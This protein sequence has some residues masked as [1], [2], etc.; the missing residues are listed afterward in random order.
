MKLTKFLIYQPT[1]F[2]RGR[3]QGEHL[4]E[5]YIYIYIYIYIKKKRLNKK[6]FSFPLGSTYSVFDFK[7]C[8]K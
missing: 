4:F 1:S 5:K 6:S 7:S 8:N 3:H 2:S